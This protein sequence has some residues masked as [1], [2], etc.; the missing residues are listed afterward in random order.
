MVI[1]SYFGNLLIVFVKISYMKLF[2]L[3]IKKISN[4]VSDLED[5]VNICIM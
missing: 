5:I 2:F 1:C 4:I 3:N